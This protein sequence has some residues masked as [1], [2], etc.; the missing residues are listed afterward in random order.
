MRPNPR[1]CRAVVAILGAP[2]AA[3]LAQT[4]T[5]DEPAQG[6]IF[7][8]GLASSQQGSIGQGAGT[9]GQLP[10]VTG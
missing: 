8:R 7:M 10:E 4:Q 5:G 3:A 9:T 2:A 6:N 1:V